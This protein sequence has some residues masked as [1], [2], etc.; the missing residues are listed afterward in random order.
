M[1][2]FTN[3]VA[4]ENAL[5]RA[6]DHVKAFAW[7]D[8]LAFG[9]LVAGNDLET[10]ANSRSFAY[11]AA[12][13]DEDNVVEEDFKL[14]NMELSSAFESG[15]D[16]CLLFGGSLTDQLQLAQ[17]LGWLSERPIPEQAKAK[18]MQVDGSLSVFGDGALLEIAKVAESIPAGTHAI[19]AIAWDAVSGSDPFAVEAAL[20]R[21]SFEGLASLAAGLARWLQELPSQE[22]GLSISQLQT[23]DAVRLGVT[24]PRDLYAAVQATE[25]TPFRIDWE[26]WA[27][28][29]G[30]C[31]G[32]D[33]LLRTVSGSPFL[34]PPRDLAFEAFDAQLLELTPRGIALLSGSGNYLGGSFPE[35]WLGGFK[36]DA[37]SSVFWD[38]AA[39]KIVGTVDV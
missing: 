10:F 2:I 13:W 26:F 32:S 29:D 18:L 17:I 35:R 9:R 27:V 6:D 12:S 33:P 3:E 36:I 7:Q 14:R 20:E 22:N 38:Y 39:R 4:T 21:A 5:K 16:V 8:P 28:I 11:A 24:S 19:Y 15:E 25:E 37:E 1:R 30:L 31:S 34:C 23:L